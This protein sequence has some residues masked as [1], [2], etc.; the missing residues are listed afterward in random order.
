MLI[1]VAQICYCDFLFQ[2][3]R[4]K[5]TRHSSNPP[6]EAHIGWV[7]DSREHRPRSASI[8]S[9]CSFSVKLQS[10]T[11]MTMHFIWLCYKG[12]KQ[13][14]NTNWSLPSFTVLVILQQLT[15]VVVVLL[16]TGD[17]FPLLCIKHDA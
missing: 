1:S 9:D 6:Q 17:L 7:M 13:K 16:G 2:M 5:K 15:F 14:K 11:V 10:M 3:Q 4:K 8:R 12:D